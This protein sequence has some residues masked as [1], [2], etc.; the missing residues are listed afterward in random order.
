MQS[1]G[2]DNMQSQ[3]SS[4]WVCCPRA[5]MVC[6]ARHYWTLSICSREM[7]AFHARCRSIVCSGQGP[8]WNASPYVLQ[9]Y[10]VS[11]C[12]DVIPH[13]SRPTV[14]AVEG[15]RWHVTP[16]VI[17][18]LVLPNGDDGI[19]RTISSHHVCCTMAM[20]ASHS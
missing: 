19:E 17:R 9:L 3:T 7:M 12:D 16:D 15:Q 2:D 6:Q 18:P 13:R 10:M 5:M 4:E 8:G 11:K 20:M 14:S 1:K